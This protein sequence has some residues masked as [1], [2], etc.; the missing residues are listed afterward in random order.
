MREATSVSGCGDTIYIK[1]GVYNISAGDASDIEVRSFKPNTPCSGEGASARL[2]ITVDP[3]TSGEVVLN[4]QGSYGSGRFLS[5]LNSRGV[6]FD[7]AGRLIVDGSDA[8]IG[9]TGALVLIHSYNDIIEDII[10]E[11]VEVRNSSGRGISFLQEVD[12]AP[13]HI[14]IQNNKVHDIDYRAIGGFGNTVS[15]LDNEVWNAAMSNSN[16]AFGGSGWPGVI[17]MARRSSGGIYHYPKN[18]FVNDNRIH[19]SWGEGVIM[20]FTEGGEVRDNTIYDVFSNYIYLDISQDINVINN[21]LFR[22]TSTYDRND[23]SIGQANGIAFGAESYSWGNGQT[24]HMVENIVIANNL[25]DNLGKGVSFWHDGS[26]NYSTNSYRNIYILHNIFRSLTYTPFYIDNVP[27]GY[28]SPS[29]GQ[30]KNNVI[31]NSGRSASQTFQIGDTTAWSFS[32]NN[33]TGGLPNSGSHPGSHAGDPGYAGQ[34]LSIG[35]APENYQIAEG[36]LNNATG[37]GTIVDY[38]YWGEARHSEHPSIGIHEFTMNETP[39][40]SAPRD[41]RI[42]LD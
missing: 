26:N 11:R 12:A 21:R 28:T 25:V 42:E 7:G 10:F 9:S 32:H 27:S 18:I 31:E 22:T 34:D 1:D 17:Q 3:A 5:L 24:P 14:Y 23:K 41:F 15:I 38:D 13:G 33:W 35:S 39:R 19:D 30:I 37:I 29:N 16:Q 8:N 2:L 36:S 40:L 6:R 4:A 20:H